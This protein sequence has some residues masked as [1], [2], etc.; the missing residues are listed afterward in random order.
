VELWSINYD[1]SDDL[2]ITNEN[3]PFLEEVS[4]NYE[5]VAIKY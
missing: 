3:E 4:V 1:G 5:P 2:Q